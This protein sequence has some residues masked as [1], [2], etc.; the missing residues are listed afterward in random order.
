MGFGRGRGH[1]RAIV[2]YLQQD[3]RQT[4][5]ELARKLGIAP[6]TR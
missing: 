3:A 6:S 5:R 2:T 1:D 4:N